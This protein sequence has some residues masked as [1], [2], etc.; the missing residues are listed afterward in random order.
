MTMLK[1]DPDWFSVEIEMLF[2]NFSS[3]P[4][5]EF[6]SNELLQLAEAAS[7]PWTT[8]N[9]EQSWLLNLTDIMMCGLTLMGMSQVTLFRLWRKSPKRTGWIYTHS[10]GRISCAQ[11]GCVTLDAQ[12]DLLLWR[13]WVIILDDSYSLFTASY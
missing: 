1:G 7:S 13:N 5:K 3:F 6:F 10:R 11:P 9:W 2:G 4:K 8:W 12:T